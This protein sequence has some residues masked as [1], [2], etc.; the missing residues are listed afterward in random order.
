MR[1]PWILMA[2]LLLAAG[3]HAQQKLVPAQ[4]EI[5]FVSKQM[6]V[7]VEGKFTRFDAQIAFDPKKPETGKAA[8]TI[9]LASASLGSAE[10]ETELKQP[11]WLNSAKVPQATFASTAIKAVGGGKF[12]ISGKLTI[13]GNTRD[14]VVPAT[15]TQAG[16]ST[17]A[18]GSFTLKRVDYKIGEGEWNDVSIVA[19]DVVVRFKLVLTGVAAL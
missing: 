11:G 6:G 12:E 19:N 16:A 14:V 18:A 8:F 3:V 2:G 10:T 1:K 13:K 5:V 15:L 7:P 17:T 9:D 4:S